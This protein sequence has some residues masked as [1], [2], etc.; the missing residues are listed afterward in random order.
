MGTRA[1]PRTLTRS[2]P[3][4]VPPCIPTNLA[5]ESKS[6]LPAEAY[7]PTQPEKCLPRWSTVLLTGAADDTWAVV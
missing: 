4:Q 1:C 3:L 2:A 7:Q 5:N 6:R